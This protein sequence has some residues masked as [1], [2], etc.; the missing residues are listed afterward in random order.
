MTKNLISSPTLAHLTENCAPKFFRE[1]YL[2]LLLDIVPNYDP[3][4]F[5]W[6]L[7]NK[8]WEN[9]K[10]SHFGPNFG[11]FHPNLDPKNFFVSFNS[12]SS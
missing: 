8:T 4:Q 10:K 11:P 2:Y 6:K 9:D 5:K 12:T 7:M 1:F 3:M